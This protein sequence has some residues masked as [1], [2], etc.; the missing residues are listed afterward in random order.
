MCKF[1]LIIFAVA[2]IVIGL[3]LTIGPFITIF[4]IITILFIM[5]VCCFVLIRM[6]LGE[7]RLIW[8]AD[9]V[10]VAD[11]LLDSTHFG[12]EEEEEQSHG[13]IET[14]ETEAE[15]VM[16]SKNGKDSEDQSRNE[17]SVTNNFEM[18]VFTVTN[19]EEDEKE[20]ISKVHDSSVEQFAENSMNLDEN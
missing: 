13:R 20:S 9:T 8:P 5:L 11:A 16:D 17:N 15:E 10:F 1:A 14:V 2:G 12:D 3:W 4:I 19:E 6:A 18:V 7:G